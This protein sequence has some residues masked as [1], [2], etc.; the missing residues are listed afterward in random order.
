[1]IRY[2]E[3]LFDMKKIMKGKCREKFSGLT[4]PNRILYTTKIIIGL[5][6]LV[7]LTGCQYR[8]YERPEMP[9]T[10][11]LYR[12][13]V[14]SDDTASI[15]DLSWKELFTDPLLQQ[16]I[17]TGIANNTDLNI[18]RLKVR[19]AEAVSNASKLAYLPS[20]SL[21]PQGTLKSV[22][23]NSPTKTYNLAASADWEL[24]I[25]GRI[26]NA[27]RE[28]KAVLEQSEAY[29][30]AVHT[31]LVAT[32][33]NSYY[34][35]LMLDEQLDITRRTA[36]NW[37]EN[38][39]VMKALKNAGQTTEMAVAQIEASKLAVDASVLSLQQQV[40]EMENSLSA[41]LGLTPQTIERS[42]LAGQTFPDTLSVG[43]PLQLLQRRP[44]VRQSEA[45]LA[46]AFYATNRAYSAFYPSITLSGSAGWTNAAGAVITNPGEWLF[47]AVGSLVQPLFN[48]GENSANLK[49]A[50]A[51]QEEALL[52]FRQTL[53]DAGTEVNNALLQWQVARNRLE[54]DKQQVASLQSAVRSSELLMQYSSQNYLEVLTARQTLLSA[55]LSAVA[56]RFDEI[57]GVINLYHA[58]GGGY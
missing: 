10:D 5:W 46:E 8:V 56:D 22:E 39:R 24:D 18:A 37:A 57:Q 35:L 50:K 21:T 42:T 23:G 48:R 26:T 38:L 15:A 20:L 16:L 19:E 45:A 6:L 31:Q 36:E 9:Q 1:M 49:V 2:S 4:M 51:Q 32:I 43:V 7:G 55:E 33:A 29:K 17:E 30:Q 25:F 52:T 53:L 34:S 58:L 27:K 44:D 47:T 14:A 11:S 13:P 12:Q 40:T 28:A 41:L 54:L 3:Q